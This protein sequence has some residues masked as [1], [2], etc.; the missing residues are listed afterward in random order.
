MAESSESKQL[1]ESD[2]KYFLNV[3][4]LVKSE[5]VKQERETRECIVCSSRTED[6]HDIYET[7]TSCTK[8]YL[9]DFLCK[10]TQVKLEDRSGFSRYMCQFCYSLIN[11]LEEAE[12][13]YNRLKVN[14]ESIL[15]KN[16]LFALA[17]DAIK[18]ECTRDD[19]DDEPLAITKIKRHKDKKNKKRLLEVGGKNKKRKKDNILLEEMA[20]AELRAPSPLDNGFSFDNLKREC[21]EEEDSPDEELIIDEKKS[22]RGQKKQKAV[23]KCDECDAKYC[24]P[25]RLMYHKM[26]H[27]GSKPP[28]ICEI[29]G[30][31]YKHR[32]AC[33]VHIAMHKGISD[34]KC[35]ECDK[36]F[37][38]KAALQRHN[39]IHTGKANYQCD[40]CGKSFIHTSSFKMHK[41]AHSGVKP[42]TCGLCGLAL[43][44]RSHLK[45]HARVHSGEKKHQCPLCG[46][47]FSE[48]YNLVAH[49]KAHDAGVSGT[50]ASPAQHAALQ[51]VISGGPRRRLF[52]CT[53]CEQRFERRYMLERHMETVHER[54]LERAP[55]KPRNTMSKLLKAQ[56]AGSGAGADID[57]VK[58]EPPRDS[59]RPLGLVLNSGSKAS[60][61]SDAETSRSCY[62]SYASYAHYTS[63]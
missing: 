52:R 36:L 2:N 43:M 54:P 59:E 3:I 18:V 50:R 51:A 63:A 24:S 12:A 16:P 33:D 56:A 39:N 22:K 40:L 47:R 21:T 32:K 7:R 20:H 5:H 41:L 13:E 27:E 17:P 9:Y 6:D 29:C 48:R 31:H 30:A 1:L 55:P 34:W 53:Y 57:T 61:T 19:S 58:H 38:S 15:C 8:S 14:F 35:E 23:H 62:S 49:G 25:V 46:K 42:H 4:E 37:P 45:R 11:I 26:K 60:E 10:F 28:Y 44:T